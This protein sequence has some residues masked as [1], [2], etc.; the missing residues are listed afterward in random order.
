MSLSRCSLVAWV[1]TFQWVVVI[2]FLGLSGKPMA[3][4]DQPNLTHWGSNHVGQGHPE[5]IT[6]D[7]CLFCHRDI[8]P[9]WPDNP[10]QTTLRLTDLERP[11]IQ[12]LAKVAPEVAKQVDFILGEDRMVRFLKRSHEYGLLDLLSARYATQVSTKNGPALHPQDTK[13]I[14]WHSKTFADRCAGCHT[15]A[16]DSTSRTF[17]ATSLDC[18]VCHGPVDNEHTTDV[19]QVLLSTKPQD[20]L[21][22]NS[23]C[24]SCHLRGGASR[25][26]KFPY[27]ASFVPGD[28]LFLDFQVDLSDAAIALLPP[29]QQHIY[30]S[31][32]MVG[33]GQAEPTCIDCHS[34]HHNQSQP[35]TDLRATKICLSCHSPDSDNSQLI[36]AIQNYDRATERNTTCD[37]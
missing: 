24:S 6:G 34:V 17:S 10:H 2:A 14:A 33:G 19:T 29:M 4:A 30:L 18:Y 21:V 23:I 25:T 3:M 28:N 9:A 22:V 13:D 31:A 11:E 8:G 35:H 7:E 16:V 37:Y 15:T 27:P 5:Y 36:D 32:R 12:S 1:G 20:P 26:T